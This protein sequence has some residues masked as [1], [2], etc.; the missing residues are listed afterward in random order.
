LLLDEP[1]NHLDLEMRHALTLALQGFTGAVVVISHDR[2]LLKNTVDEFLL[3]DAGKVTAFDGDLH[4]YE[5]WV[6]A[7]SRAEAQADNPKPDTST[8]PKSDKRVSRQAAAAKRERLQPVTKKIKQLDRVI[9]QLSDE[10]NQLERQ[11]ADSDLYLE[12]ADA[13]HLQALLQQ[14]AQAR[15]KLADVEEQWLEQSE[16]L[17]ALTD[18]P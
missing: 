15:A 8:Q 13:S 16:L 5:R 10:L 18:E 12:S 2:H 1:T 3:V 11:L 6:V 7:K 9:G 14:Q 17:E 4:D